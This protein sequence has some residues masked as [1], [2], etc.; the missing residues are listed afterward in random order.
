MAFLQPTSAIGSICD[1]GAVSLMASPDIK[2]G[3]SATI[4]LS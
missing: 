4:L 2:A 1:A 3:T